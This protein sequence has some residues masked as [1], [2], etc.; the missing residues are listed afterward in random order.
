MDTSR[1]DFCHPYDPYGIQLQFMS[2]LY[3][4]IEERKVAVFESPTGTGKSLS[5]ICGSMTWLRDH[6]RKTNEKSLE[7]TDN[8]NDPEWMIEAEKHE[9]RRQLLRH[10]E[11]LE[12]RL[13]AARN[14]ETSRK[15]R[16]GES[17][18]NNKRSVSCFTPNH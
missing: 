18:Q 14:A 3:E 10:R 5:L 16:P 2:S 15:A 6:K 8:A 4:C 9:R 12:K 13:L 11:E 7:A 1:R 17:L